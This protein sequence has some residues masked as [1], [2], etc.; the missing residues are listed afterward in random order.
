MN[1]V[2]N[3]NNGDKFWQSSSQPYLLERVPWLRGSTYP[4]FVTR[5]YLS[6]GWKHDRPLILLSLNSQITAHTQRIHWLQF[7][8]PWNSVFTEIWALPFHFIV[9]MH[10][11][12]RL[13]PG[14]PD[15]DK[16][17]L[18]PFLFFLP[19]FLADYRQP[20]RWPL[21]TMSESNTIHSPL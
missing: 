13:S 2:E 21:E 4:N 8:F 17:Y 1:W 19:L 9:T 14:N 15:S 10:S 6:Q 12:A 18:T 5:I 3:K 7:G 16:L 11:Y 20:S